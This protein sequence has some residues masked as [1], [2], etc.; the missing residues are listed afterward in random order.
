MIKHVIFDLG[1]VLI[2]FEPDKHFQ[3]FQL[4]QQ[5]IQAIMHECFETNLWNE[6]DRGTYTYRQVA[7]ILA[8]KYPDLDGVIYDIL[9]EEFYDVFTELAD[10]IGFLKKCVADGY[11]CYYLSNFGEEGFTYVKQKFS[12]FSLFK[13]GIA[14]YELRSTKPEPEI[15]LHLLEKYNLKAQECIFLDDTEKNVRAARELGLHGIVYTN[16][17][18]VNEEFAKLLID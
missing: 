3:K 14:S 18:Q 10:G 17:A 4:S 13:G 16:Q 12:W 5:Q 7:G 15:Y 2:G 6:L 11:N 1:R 8:K 9:G